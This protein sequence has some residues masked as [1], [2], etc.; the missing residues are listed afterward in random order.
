M[1]EEKEKKVGKA[2]A[3]CEYYMR[4]G[5][6]DY[7]VFGPGTEPGCRYEGYCCYK[8]RNR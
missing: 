7:Q 1:E 4:G 3:W 2:K 6:R 8:R 5:L